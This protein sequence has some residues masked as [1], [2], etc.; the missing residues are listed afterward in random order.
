MSCG[1]ADRFTIVV[2]VS[3]ASIV[4]YLILWGGSVF[5]RRLGWRMADFFLI[6]AGRILLLL[7]MCGTV[8]SPG[9]VS[10]ETPATQP[11]TAPVAFTADSP[12]RKW[13][14][15]LSDPDP[16]V[17]DQAKFELMGMASA[18]LARLKQLVID[19]RPISPTQSAALRDIVVQSFLASDEYKV[20]TAQGVVQTDASGT[21]GPFFLGILWA[22]GMDVESEAR[23]GVSVDERLPGFPSYR[24]LRTGDMILGVYLDPTAPLLQLPNVETHNR[25]ALIQA[26]SNA[27]TVQDI[28]LEVLRDGQTL[29]I[30]VKMAP[31]PL[32]V[33]GNGI[34]PIRAFNAARLN[35][36]EEYWNRNFAAMV[37]ATASA[38]ANIEPSNLAA[39]P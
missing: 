15:Q 2:I 10:A 31:R 13:F 7:L 36:A 20:A 6:R 21:I 24:F 16:K 5:G 34:D 17:R 27:P 8:M 23:L 14:I 4:L 18:D 28:V 33:E 39:G 37:Q 1:C 9:Q 29:K 22:T 11:T 19:S 30:A 26:I 35:R 38:N 32:E 12:I 3:V 25:L